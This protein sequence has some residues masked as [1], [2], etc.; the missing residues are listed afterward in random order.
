METFMAS[1]AVPEPRLTENAFS[2]SSRCS[3]VSFSCAE[4]YGSSRESTHRVR[5]TA[6]GARDLDA[7]EVVVDE[8][9]IG[10]PFLRVAGPVL[11]H[12]HQ[13]MAM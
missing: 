8:L 12:Q 11:E 3:P 2:L 7:H 5:S 13:L 4:G 9:A 6:L 10:S 1:R